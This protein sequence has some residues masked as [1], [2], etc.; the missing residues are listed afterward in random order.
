MYPAVT[1]CT[2]DI[3]DPN[4]CPRGLS[5]IAKQNVNLT[6]ADSGLCT[7]CEMRIK[8]AQLKAMGH[9]RNENRQCDCTQI[10]NL[11]GASC[12]S[13]EQVAKGP[14]CRFEQ[15]FD[16]KWNDEDFPFPAPTPTP[17]EVVLRN[18]SPPQA[19]KPQQNPPGAYG[20]CCLDA[21]G[22]CP[23][24]SLLPLWHDD[25]FHDLG[26]GSHF[27]ANVDF[28][29]DPGADEQQNLNSI[30]D[31]ICALPDT[32]GFFAKSNLN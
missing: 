26:L 18:P 11:S 17:A 28:T 22:G 7:T 8:E 10:S 3:F 15:P 30:F 14:D 4:P 24:C 32:P 23:H 2:K 29:I 25:I 6:I 31:S 5:Q 20:G 19:T 21:S 13:R 9:V 27:D 16:I 12:I 1:L